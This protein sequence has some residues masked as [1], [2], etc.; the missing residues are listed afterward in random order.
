MKY[1]DQHVHT[2]FSPD[3]SSDL[4]GLIKRAKQLGLKRF[5]VTDHYEVDS[6]D[7]DNDEIIDF[8][9]FLLRFDALKLEHPELDLRLGVELGYQEHNQ[10]QMSDITKQYPFDFVIASIHDGD[11]K[12][13]YKG[14]FF[15]NKT[16][17]EAYHHYF[18][19]M[20]D[21]VNNFTDYD[22]VGHLDYIMRYGDP[23][24]NTLQYSHHK[25]IIN[26]IL[27]V[28]IRNG[29]GIEVNT[30]GMTYYDL[31]YFHPQREIL[32][33]YY[34]LGGTIITVGSDAHQNER[35]YEHVEDVIQQLADIGFT[36]ITEFVNRKPVQIPI[37][38]DKEN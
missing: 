23:A 25:D 33:A 17:D 14:D 6:N 12:S 8:D 29:K 35:L 27:K 15:L 19:L 22:V 7:F 30:S 16:Q 10:Q 32:E 2:E 36:S 18:Q 4:L 1:M 21:M 34:N 5:V 38:V 26:E 31:G 28:I 20:L 11:R 24:I 37:F 3:A 9:S 13:F